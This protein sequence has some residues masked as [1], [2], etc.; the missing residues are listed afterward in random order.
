MTKAS[1]IKLTVENIFLYM[2][3]A[4]CFLVKKNFDGIMQNSVNAKKN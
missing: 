3:K 2:V 1:S 4:Y